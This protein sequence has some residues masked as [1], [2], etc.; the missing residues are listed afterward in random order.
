MALDVALRGQGVFAFELH[1]EVDMRRAARIGDRLDRA[2][3]VF[4]RGAGDKAAEALKIP[5]SVLGVA[6]AGVRIS[7]VVVA[8]PD[9]YGGVLER[10]PAG[11]ENL[12]AQVGDC[13]D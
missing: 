8:L 4:A 3:D 1:L 6:R 11:V 10:I 2:E 5:V 9:F 12:A 7:P 13:P